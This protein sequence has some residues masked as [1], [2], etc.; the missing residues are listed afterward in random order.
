MVLFKRFKSNISTI[1]AKEGNSQDK[2]T[3]LKLYA[4]LTG[5]KALALP[6]KDN[7][8]MHI[9][10][11]SSGVSWEVV[12]SVQPDTKKKAGAMSWNATLSTTR[13]AVFAEF[14]WE[15][16]KDVLSQS[17]DVLTNVGL[18]HVVYASLFRYDRHHSVLCAF[19]EH[20]CSVTNTL[21][22][23]QGEMSISLWDLHRIG[24]LPI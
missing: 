23:T 4:P 7:N 16:L 17:K 9:K 6:T 11:W 13:E 24:G 10:S 14:Y 8:S 21:H 22:T 3:T 12:N 15:W 1:L 18:Y 20:W 5:P 2:G 19:F